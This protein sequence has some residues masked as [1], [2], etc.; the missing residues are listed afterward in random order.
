MRSRFPRFLAVLVLVFLQPS[1]TAA[2]SPIQS[3]HEL[4]NLEAF[5]RAYGYVRFFHPSDEAAEVDWDKLAMVGLESVRTADH[6]DALR[7]RLLDVLGPLAPELQVTLSRPE[8]RSQRAS[9]GPAT[10]WQYQGINLSPDRSVYQQ[11]RVVVEKSL[12]KRQP[13]FEQQNP[14]ERLIREIGARLWIEMPLTLPIDDD[15]R[16]HATNRP[17][18]VELERRLEEIDLQTVS[19]AGWRVRLAGVIVVWNVFQHFH[20][21]LDQAGIDWSATLAPALQEAL[22]AEDA[23]GYNQVLSALVAKSNDGHGYVYGPGRAS[24]GLPLRFAWIDDE[25]IISGVEGEDALQKGGIVETLDGR[26][27]AQA[28][29]DVER[30]SPGSPHLRRF[31]ALN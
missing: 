28:L 25:L 16:T 29:A 10:Y 18:L 6:A 8:A 19:T 24:A 12:P 4:K 14:P 22:E 17:G 15:G 13:L 2:P 9:R 27:A 7:T 3:P 20:P 11:R 1:L 21:Y 31:R 26:P 23:A 5:A 30:R